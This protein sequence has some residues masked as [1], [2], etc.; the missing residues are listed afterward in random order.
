MM[1]ILKFYDVQQLEFNVVHHKIFIIKFSL[2]VVQQLE[3]I[4]VQHKI[5]L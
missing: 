4:V 3:K 1:K 5:F 2:I